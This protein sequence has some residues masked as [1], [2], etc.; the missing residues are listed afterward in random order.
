M[1]APATEPTARTPYRPHR[2]QLLG[3]QAQLY[4]LLLD[5]LLAHEGHIRLPR[6]TTGSQVQPLLEH[7]RQENPLALFEGA[8]VVRCYAFGP[9]GT[10][11]TLEVRYRTDAAELQKLM[12]QAARDALHHCGGPEAGEAALALRFHDR[13]AAQ[14]RYVPDATLAHEAA[15]ALVYGEA[16]CDGIAK[17]YKLLCDEAGIPCAV[18]TGSSGGPHAWNVA[19]IAGHWAHMDVTDDLA[20]PR[21]CGAKQRAAGNRVAGGA[22]DKSA[23][24]SRAYFGLSD[25]EL[26]PG[27]SIDQPCP[28]CPHNLGLYRS[29]GL[30]AKNPAQLASLC[31]QQFERGRNAF[32]VEL[33][34]EF[35]RS[36]DAPAQTGDSLL[37]VVGA[38]LLQAGR[39]GRVQLSSRRPGVVRVTVQDS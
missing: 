33:G 20:L 39:S 11:S 8:R 17:A 24:I 1:P 34:S 14:C 6:G 21:S 30:H 23:D 10:F 35:P 36:A 37:A 15:G 9:A 7:I 4:D 3:G 32:E 18:V 28:A 5:G 22:D 2:T 26:P 25:R 16:V 31:R 13:L 38:S 19:R 12:Q 29:L 27:R